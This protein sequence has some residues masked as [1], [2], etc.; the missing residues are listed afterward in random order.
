[1]TDF[2]E[3]Y[4]T[5]LPYKICVRCI[6][7]TTVAGIE[8]DDKGECNF[9]KVHDE[10]CKQYRNDAVGSEILARKLEKVKRKGKNKKYDC[11][12]GVSGGRDSTYLLFKAVKEWNL[13]PLAVHFNDGF[14][15]PVGGENI[16]NAVQILNVDLVTITSDWREAKDLKISFLK[17]ST[18]DLNQGTDVGIASSLFG[19]AHKYG[20]KTI[21]F[22]QSFR[23][24]G[25]KP[26]SWTYFDGDYLRN[27]QKLLGSVPLRKWTANDPGFNLGIKELTYYN[28]FKGIKVIAPLYYC[29]YVRSNADEIISKELKWVNP[30]AHYYDDLYWSLINYVH[31]VKFNIDLRINSYSALIRSGQMTRETALERVSKVYEIEDPKIIDLCIK[32]LGITRADFDEYMKLPP[33]NFRFYP[34]SYYYMTK[35]SWAIKL[36]TIVGFLPKSVYLK[37][38]KNGI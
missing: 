7:D 35:F 24:E 14:D 25:I 37:Y 21:L 13:R 23:T 8:F 11:V 5:K 32:R 31:R 19:V 16:L 33:K 30:G 36:L 10:L 20:I 34:N 17:A 6:H 38:F 15:N 1:M 12:I 18:P 2:S 9:C 28:V 22:G 4:S 3:L 27:V 26:I 29:N